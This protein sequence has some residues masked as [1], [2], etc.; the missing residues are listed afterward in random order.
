MNQLTYRQERI[1]RLLNELR[2]EIEIGMIQR[3]I[4]EILTFKFFVPISQSI[5]NGVVL[6]KFETRPVNRYS[7]NMDLNEPRLKIV[8]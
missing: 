3:E 6:C 7:A 8:K 5:P 2:Y 1:E 4:S